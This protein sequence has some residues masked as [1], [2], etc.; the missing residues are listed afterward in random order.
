VTYRVTVFDEP[1][2]ATPLGTVTT[3]GTGATE[4]TLTVPTTDRDEG[5][6]TFFHERSETLIKGRIADV[7]PDQGF[8]EICYDNAPD[9]GDNCPTAGRGHN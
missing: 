5:E 6:F 4:L 7:A 2:D 1:G 8:F 9:A 3:Q